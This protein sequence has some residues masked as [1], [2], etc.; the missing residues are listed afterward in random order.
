MLVKAHKITSSVGHG[1]QGQA[2]EPLTTSQS[3]GMLPAKRS[4]SR[5]DN[6]QQQQT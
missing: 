6:E 2:A 1:A 4:G 3:V 5:L